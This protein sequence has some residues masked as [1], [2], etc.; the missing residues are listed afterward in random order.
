[1]LQQ[2]GRFEEEFD[3]LLTGQQRRQGS[4]GTQYYLPLLHNPLARACQC[5]GCVVAETV[6]AYIYTPVLSLA[7]A[8]R[9]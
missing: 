9:K 2:F 8:T 7:I 3:H 4:R 6:H 5:Y 1:M